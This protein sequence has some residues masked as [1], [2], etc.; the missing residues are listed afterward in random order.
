M[1][2]KEGGKELFHEE[3]LFSRFATPD[4][5][6]LFVQRANS[7]RYKISLLSPTFSLLPNSK[8]TFENATMHILMHIC[9]I[10]RISM[11]RELKFC[12]CTKIIGGFREIKGRPG[13]KCTVIRVSSHSA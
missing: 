9:E 5:V 8:V 7:I 11:R 3:K 6:L 1:Q 10:I 2:G 13:T 12:A 4:F